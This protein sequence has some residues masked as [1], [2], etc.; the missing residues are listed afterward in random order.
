[1]SE[2]KLNSKYVFHH[3]A[4]MRNVQRRVQA[5]MPILED[6]INGVE[7]LAVAVEKAEQQNPADRN[8]PAKPEESHESCS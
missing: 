7:R 3:L 8:G 2:R 1:M 6:A 4:K 5:L